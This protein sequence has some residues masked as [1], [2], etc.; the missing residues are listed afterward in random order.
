MLTLI[1]WQNLSKRLPLSGAP[2]SI[3]VVGLGNPILSDDGI[4]WR[5]S[6]YVRERLLDDTGPFTFEAVRVIEASVGG[7]ALAELLVDYQRAIIVDAIMTRGGVPGTVYHLKLA[8]LSGTLNT[9]SAQDTNLSTALRA[10]RRFGAVLPDDDAIDLIAVEVQDVLTF[11]ERCS[12]AVTASIPA[13]G[14]AVMR[15]LK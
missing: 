13:A 4:G 3:L 5:V 1:S 12:P 15:L 14:E 7:L 11:A 2:A 10:L 9:A 6:Q 8:D